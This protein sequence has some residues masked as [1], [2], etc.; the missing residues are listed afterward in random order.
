M[1]SV[2]I[3]IHDYKIKS[4]SEQEI[5]TAHQQ[6]KRM[7]GFINFEKKEIMINAERDEITLSETMIHE[8]LHGLMWEW[9]IQDNLD[10]SDEIEEKLVNTLAKGLIQV[11]RQMDFRNIM[12]NLKD[13]E[14]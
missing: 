1:S 13:K 11:M 9:D 12:E 10:I 2:R 3:G 6:G 8:V 7:N 5:N 4:V 14:K